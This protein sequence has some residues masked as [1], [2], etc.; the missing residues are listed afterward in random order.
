MP[1]TP[2]DIDTNAAPTLARTVAGEDL[3]VDDF[4]TPFQQTWELPSYLWNT[5]DHAL[6]P[7]ELVRLTGIADRAGQPLKVLGICLPFVYAQ[8]PY[9][10]VHT[11]DLRRMSLVRLDPGTGRSIWRRMKGKLD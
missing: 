11:L 2:P 5:C 10:T 8:D 7:D 4:V 1:A 9:R 6:P 3:R